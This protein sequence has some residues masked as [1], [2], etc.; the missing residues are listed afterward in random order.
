MHEDAALHVHSDGGVIYQT[1]YTSVG[2]DVG[3]S[4]THL[5]IFRRF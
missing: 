5:T 2:I 4:T 3:S 1:R